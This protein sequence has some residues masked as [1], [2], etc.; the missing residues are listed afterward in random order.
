M[1]KEALFATRKKYELKREPPV[2]F[3]VFGLH[4][5]SLKRL[6]WQEEGLIITSQLALARLWLSMVH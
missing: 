2:E 1:R 3:L 4:S 5:Q 6:V